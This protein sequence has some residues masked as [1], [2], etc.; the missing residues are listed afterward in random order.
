MRVEHLQ[1]S[2]CRDDFLK[3]MVE[4]DKKKHEAKV[5]KQIISTKR[6]PEQPKEAHFVKAENVEF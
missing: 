4:N 5:K 1:K 2:K 6:L 3:R